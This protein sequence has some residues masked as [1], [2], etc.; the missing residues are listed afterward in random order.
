MS[1]KKIVLLWSSPNED[2][3]TA[4][5]AKETAQGVLSEDAEL[6]CIHVNEQQLLHCRACGNGWGLCASEGRCVQQDDFQSIYDQLVAA[7]GIILVTA[8]Y[9]HDVTECMKA[10]LDR[11]RRCETAH[12]H[13]L[14]GKSTLLIACAGGS[15]RGATQCLYIMEDTLSHMKMTAFDRLPVTRFNRSYMLPAVKE[16]GAAFV[17]SLELK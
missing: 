7:D 17:Q 3:L 12:N 2:G 13:A 8:V 6:T 10:L 16:A 11:L 5:A 4:A 1:K 14:T 15:G 9:W